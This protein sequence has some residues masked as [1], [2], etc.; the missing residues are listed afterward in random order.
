MSVFGCLCCAGR[1]QWLSKERLLNYYGVNEERLAEIEQIA[2]RTRKEQETLRNVRSVQAFLNFED[3]D[4]FKTSDFKLVIFRDQ[5]SIHNSESHPPLA[6]ESESDQLSSSDPDSESLD[7]D[8]QSP[9]F[10]HGRLSVDHQ[11]ARRDEES[12]QGKESP[13]CCSSWDH[14]ECMVFRSHA[15][16]AHSTAEVL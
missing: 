4:D 10:S 5:N 1:S 15:Q 7:S 6:P 16:L 12:K 11:L 8:A 3:V 13:A 2:E 14:R 9:T